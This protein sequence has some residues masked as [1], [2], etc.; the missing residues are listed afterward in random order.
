MTSITIIVIVVVA[1][2]TAVIFGFAW[3]GYASCLKAFKLEVSQGKHDDEIRKEYI[4]INKRK[5]V[6]VKVICYTMTF[7]LLC[8]LIGLFI[9]G[10]SYKASGESLTINNK[11]V[12]VIKSGSMSE[13]YD[14][15]ISE[16]YKDLGYDSR[17][18]FSVGDICICEKVSP[19][20][21]LTLGEV[22]GYKHKNII[23][24]HRLIGTYTNNTGEVF[25][26]FRGDNNPGKDQILVPANNIIYHYTGNRLQVIGSF[27][28]YAQSYLGIWSLVCLVGIIIGSDIVLH[29]IQKLS[30]QRAEEIRGAIND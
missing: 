22:Y 6:I 26:I 17:L 30:K 13:Y 27:I 18:Q 23:I 25:Y 16:K 2:L 12:L 28:L 9:T 19:E 20:E 24:V 14:E 10:L 15:D 1:I 8:V 29:K 21:A 3:L 4:N 5:Q 7:I 11:T